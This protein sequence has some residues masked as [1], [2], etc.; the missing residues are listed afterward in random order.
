MSRTGQQ[1]R[2]RTAAAMRQ[3]TPHEI[4]VRSRGRGARLRYW[5]DNSMS[6][7][8]SAL[9]AW[10]ALITLL[11]I[12]VFTVVVAIFGLAGDDD[13]PTDF[14]HQLLRS[15]F[16]ALDPGTVTGDTGSWRFVLVMLALTVAGLLIVSALIG[17]IATGIDAKLSDLR[18][19]RSVVIERNHTVILGWSDAVFT[20]IGEL[21]IAN[22]SRRRPVV[23]VLAAQDKV[24]MEDAIREKVPDLH[25]TRV[26][27]RTGSPIDLGDLA[28]SSHTS[29]RSV[30]VLSPRGDSPDSEVIKTLLALTRTGEGPPIIA[31]IQ[32]PQNLEAARLAG[33]ERAVLVDKQETVARLI[34]QTSR[35]SGAA[36]VY[37][38]LFDFDG[39]EIYFHE[40]PELAGSSYAEAQRAYESATVVGLFDEHGRAHL[41]PPQS[42]PVGSQPLIVLA[43][44]DSVLERPVMSNA[45]VDE[46]AFSGFAGTEEH[47][48]ETLLIGWN[49]RARSVV[50]ELEANTQPGSRL[51]I[52]T[53]Y[54]EPDLPPLSNLTPTVVRGRTTD[55]ATLEQHVHKGLDQVIVLCYSEHLTAQQADA[56]TLVSLL[57]VR[58]IVGEGLGTPAVVSEM[59]D[60]RN[61]AL[62][63][64]AHVDDVIVSDKILSLILSQLSEDARL[65]PVFADLLD[66]E[67]SEIYLRPV[68]WYV[69]G[70]RAT[71]A[72]IVAAAGARGETA[73]GFRS[74]TG[75]TAGGLAG[76]TLNPAKSQVFDLEAGDRVV[77]LA[78]S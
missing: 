11:L 3:T 14:G 67:G 51:T 52:L 43:E 64:V 37:I 35:Q 27:C 39:D 36:A 49:E 57:H 56:R 23:V 63:E 75:A 2:Q 48:S 26:V 33:G 45:D 12:L 72:T 74:Q 7:G 69:T 60:D 68:E 22:E 19:G 59:L 18:R 53:Q 42:T 30:I 70:S 76:V 58:E 13:D 21:A 5:F 46:A 31:E 78:E 61:R 40:A 28:L 34:V 8:T 1:M 20:I 16:H 41:N 55:R 44:D 17:V 50:R 38:E 29:A 54:G 9:V 73:L 15:L 47:P 32:D 66:A 71:F 62:A 10:L 24:D 77:V 65:G 6:R 25:G 4:E